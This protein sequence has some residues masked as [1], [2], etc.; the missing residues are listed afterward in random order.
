MF[1]CAAKFQ[2][3]SLN[4]NVLQGPDLT[5]TLIG[6]LLRFRHEPVAL[7]SDVE[8]MFHRVRVNPD[9]CDVL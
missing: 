9:N 5:N 3:E 4:D 6:V 1:D 2:G 7:I 8:S